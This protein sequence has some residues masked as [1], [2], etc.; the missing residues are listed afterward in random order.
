LPVSAKSWFRTQGGTL[1]VSDD[2][3][4]MT[5]AEPASGFL[6]IGTSPPGIFRLRARWVCLNVFGTIPSG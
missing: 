6:L 5:G 4:G 1:T 2:G 3:D